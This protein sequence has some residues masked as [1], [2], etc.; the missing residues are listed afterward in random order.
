MRKMK[1]TW[2]KIWKVR[3]IYHCY[4]CM[5]SFAGN[6]TLTLSLHAV[7]DMETNAW[8][9][10]S[11]D[12]S[13]EDSEDDDDSDNSTNSSSNTDS[14]ESDDNNAKKKGKKE[15]DNRKNAENKK[16]RGVRVEIEYEDENELV[17]EEEG[18]SG[19]NTEAGLAW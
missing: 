8:D 2:S 11:N 5:L 18:L 12:D 10:D 17:E 9:N 7:E 4:V 13:E 16:P 14:A 19:G 15:S 6:Y 3:Q 1:R